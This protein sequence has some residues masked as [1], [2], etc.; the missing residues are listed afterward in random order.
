[1]NTRNH[2]YD[3]IEELMMDLALYPNKKEAIIR[4]AGNRIY[5][6]ANGYIIVT[7][8]GK[9][10]FFN[11]DYELADISKIGLNTLSSKI[12]PDNIV[13]VIVPE[14][15]THIGAYAFNSRYL[16]KSVTLPK[17]LKIIGYAAFAY[18]AQLTE[19]TIPDNVQRIDGAAFFD[20][21][22]LQ[23]IIFGKRVRAIGSD[24][25]LDCNN[26]KEV[27]FKGKTLDRV[28]RMHCYPFGIRYGSIIKCESD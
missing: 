1:M 16:L 10:W 28:K 15:I 25:L 13:N 22:G 9:C 23:K 7:N 17:S 11:A 26:L 6:P 27:I 14:T 24:A 18:D 8:D 4:E 2:S 5:Q 20:C 19:M 21:S 12:M 3:C